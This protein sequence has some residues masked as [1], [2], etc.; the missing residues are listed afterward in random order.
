MVHKKPSTLKTFSKILNEV[1]ITEEIKNLEAFFRKL[2][3]IIFVGTRTVGH[4]PL[5][6]L[7]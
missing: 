1:F 7:I 4:I 5:L 3:F 6:C 2:M